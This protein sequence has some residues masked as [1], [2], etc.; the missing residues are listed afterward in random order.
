MTSVPAAHFDAL[1]ARDADPWGFETSA[2]EAEKYAA[3]L[4]ALDRPR[5]SAAAEI[6]CSIGVLTFRLAPCC[7][8]L[9]GVDQAEAALVRARARCAGLPHVRFMRARV[10]A[11]WPDGSF[12]LI[13]LSEVLYFLDAGD[14]RAIARRVLSTLRPSGRVLLVNYVGR[15]ENPLS[16]DQAAELF[17]ASCVSDTIRPTATIVGSSRPAPP[18]DPLPQGER[19]KPGRSLLL[20][21]PCGR[22]WGTGHPGTDRSAASAGG[23]RPIAARREALWRLD[24]LAGD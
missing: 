10:P 18:P 5:F 24:L 23:L 7:D 1:Y 19:E 9:V 21:S 8:A 4:A 22:G 2:Y 16:G 12:D 3:T 15:M 13:V 17:I 20:S 6:G 11:A 14:I